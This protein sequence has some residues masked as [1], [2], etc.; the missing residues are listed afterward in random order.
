M[1]KFFASQ[2]K[3]FIGSATGIWKYKGR[4]TLSTV[5][6]FASKNKPARGS[7]AARKHQKNLRY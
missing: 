3:S 2:E 7:N 1:E 4:R 6:V 5:Y